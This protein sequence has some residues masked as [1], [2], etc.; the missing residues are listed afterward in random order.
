MAQLR[1]LSTSS[2]IHKRWENNDHGDYAQRITQIHTI[3]IKNT[4][5]GDES[6]QGSKMVPDEKM[7]GMHAI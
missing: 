2:M 7:A 6:F 4:N 1:S 5:L 3:T